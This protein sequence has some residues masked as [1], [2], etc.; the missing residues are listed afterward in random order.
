[1]S[2]WNATRRNS[3]SRSSVRGENQDRAAAAC[4]KI[5]DY[6]MWAIVFVGP[7]LFGGRH[8]LGRFVIL[9]LCV[10]ASVAWFARQ[11][12]VSQPKWNRTYSVAILFAAVALVAFQLVPLPSEWLAAIA[13]RL[14][15]ILPLWTGNPA[16]AAHLGE[17]RTLSL[18]PEETRLALATLMA[19]GLLFVT[20][21]QRVESF[22]DVKRLVRWISCSAILVAIFGIV[23]YF[24]ANG[25]FF[26]FY[27]YPYTNTAYEMKAAFTNRNHFAHFLVLGLANLLSWTMLRRDQST[28]KQNS[29]RLRHQF[30]VDANNLSMA[31]YVKLALNLGIAVVVFAILASLSRGGVLAMVSA[32]AV[33][34]VCCARAGLLNSTHVMAS[35]L[36]A[37]VIMVALTLSG[38]YE[39]VTRRL[40]NLTSRSMEKLDASQARRLVWSANVAAYKAGWLTGSGAGTHRFIYPLYIQKSIPTEY[41]HAE[42]GYLQIATENGFPGIFLLAAALGTC[43]YWCLRAMRNAGENYQFQIL[44][45]GIAAALTASA[46]H[47]VVD[48]VWFIPACATIAVL[49]AACAF[50]L[51]QLSTSLVKQPSRPITLSAVSK[52]NMA[53]ATS[54]AG[55]WIVMTL[56]PSAQTSLEWDRYLLADRAQEAATDRKAV[57][58]EQEQLNL[59][60]AE[61]M[62]ST[63]AFFHLTNV[64]RDYPQSAVARVR[65]ASSLLKRFEALQ[66]AGD[67]PMAINQI[68]QAV[69]ASNFA[70]AQ[71][72]RGWL[73][74]AFGENS[75]LLYQAYFH[76]QRAAKLC[77][78]Q[79]DAYRFLAELSF[80]E[81]PSLATYAAYSRQSLLV[82]PQNPDILFAVGNNSFIAGNL[83]DALRLFS[84]AFQSSGGHRSDI[85]RILLKNN[86]P[87]TVF[88]KVFAPDWSS[89]NLV[90]TNYK[91]A[92]N[93]E[94]LQVIYSYACRAAKQETPAA[95]T[96]K[97]GMMWLLLSGMQRDIDDPQSALE[98]LQR[99]YVVCPNDYW[100][101][102]ELGVFLVSLHKYEQAEP[103]LRWCLT[104]YPGHENVKAALMQVSRMKM[105]R[106]AST[107]Q[108]KKLK[109]KP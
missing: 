91:N 74:R 64:V 98:S 56:F 46:V 85:I 106:L 22:E 80:L 48:F 105:Q 15:E 83:D 13:P 28:A 51:A 88:L 23:Q 27:E 35:G 59:D 55:F 62:N 69:Q 44:I 1:M 10:V 94:D 77:P 58:V 103:H 93:P 65:L 41:T 5:V 37:V 53:L 87:G 17:W 72:L 108:T 70:S 52:F 79:G 26:W 42:N 68:R 61:K 76:A 89:L 90:W 86:M 104:Q 3:G 45:G 43:C 18:A 102:C 16:A 14:S 107:S 11:L 109:S 4:L 36:L 38:N 63:S 71:Q 33:M 99:A 47:S 57:G 21:V 7:H 24:T 101:R 31:P 78:L 9:S 60:E 40:E 82:A 39:D 25:K 49:M 2:H 19:Y 81:G 100:I 92:G 12:L 32:L 95:T 97:A 34:A 30:S 20:T 75:S 96:D 6:S 50:R 66:S 73:T 67:N 8:L 29:R 84:R 54:L